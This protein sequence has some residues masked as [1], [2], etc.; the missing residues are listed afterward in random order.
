MAKVWTDCRSE[1]ELRAKVG[2]VALRCL[3]HFARIGILGKYAPNVGEEGMVG[4]CQGLQVIRYGH[5]N[6]PS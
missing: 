1:G 5:T 6:E 2:L 3:R 4:A